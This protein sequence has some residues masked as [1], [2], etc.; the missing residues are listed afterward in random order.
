M[1]QSIIELKN[2]LEIQSAELVAANQAHGAAFARHLSAWEVEKDAKQESILSKEQKMQANRL[3]IH[4]VAMSDFEMTKLIHESEQLRH[5][6]I[7]EKNLLA[8]F[9]AEPTWQKKAG[10]SIEAST[11]HMRALAVRQ[12]ELQIAKLEVKSVLT[13]DILEKIN[14]LYGHFDIAHN[15]P[16]NLRADLNKFVTLL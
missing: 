11:A 13:A 10:E 14:T 16:M 7:E 8:R 12:T 9:L 4:G 5:A 2:T 3:K 6:I 1:T 15:F